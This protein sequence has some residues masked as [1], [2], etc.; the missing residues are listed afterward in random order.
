MSF[1]RKKKH[2]PSNS[3]PANQLGSHSQASQQPRYRFPTKS[4]SQSPQQMQKSAPLYPWTTHTPPPGLWPSPFPRDLHA[5]S[6]TATAAGELFLFGGKTHDRACNDLYVIST[7]DFS[8]TLLQ[9]SGDVSDP[10]YGH[11]AVLASTTLLIWGGK[12]DFGD[13]N[14]QSPSG[15]DSFYLLNLGTS[16]PFHAQEPLQLIRVSVFQYRESGPASWSMV[17]GPAVVTAIP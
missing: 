15:D 4:Q 16:D 12:T 7:R 6:T 2:S 10:R 5:I 13:Q 3:A 11:C 17:P 9:T 1:F 14:T 8:T